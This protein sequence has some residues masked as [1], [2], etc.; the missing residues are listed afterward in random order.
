M[1]GVSALRREWRVTHVDDIEGES[2]FVAGDLG[3]TRATEVFRCL[4]TAFSKEVRIR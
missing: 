4:T 3:D 2:A 1:G